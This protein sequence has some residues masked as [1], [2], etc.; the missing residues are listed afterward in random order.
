MKN[1]FVHRRDIDNPGDINSTPFHYLDNNQRGFLVDY[2]N[3]ENLSGWQFDNVIVGG[4]AF[5]N[6]FASSVKKFL[7]NQTI[8]NF[9]IWGTGWEINDPELDD[10]ARSAQLLGI[11]EWLPNTAY[12]NNWVPCVS[13]LH[14]CI[15]K[16]L[17]VLPT[18]NFLIIDHWKRQKI[19]FGA[20][21]HTRISN[22]PNSIHQVVEAIADHRWVITSSYHGAYW[23]ILLNKRVIFI[24]NPWIPKCAT[25]KYHIPQAE[26]FNFDLLDLSQKYPDAYEE[27]RQVNLEFKE[28]FLSL[29]V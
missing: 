2:P 11:R 10:L 5:P 20:L 7:Q 15:E 21:D 8:K 28:K 25:L 13:V 3:L 1:V 19:E 17:K 6:K 26:N 22:K 12:E 16:G 18:K 27:C 14:P 23:S 29:R 24:S 9:V 4:G